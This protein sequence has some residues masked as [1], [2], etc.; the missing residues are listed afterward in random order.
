M[1]AHIATMLDQERIESFRRLP[2]GG[3][4]ARVEDMPERPGTEVASEIGDRYL[5]RYLMK[6]Q[7]SDFACHGPNSGS[8]F[9]RPHWLTPTPI[10]KADV[11]SWL[12][13]FAPSD[14]RDYVLVIDPARLTS[15]QGPAWIRLG[16]GIEYYTSSVP[17]NAIINPGPIG[18]R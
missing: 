12:A 4:T 2:I 11:T 8:A 17:L 5:L 15:V 6:G 14:E 3:R 16:S 9:T 18:L 10:P 7:L 13:L 1:S